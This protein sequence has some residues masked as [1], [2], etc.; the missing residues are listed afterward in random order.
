PA[1]T[2]RRIGVARASGTGH[3]GDGQGKREEDRNQFGCAHGAALIGRVINQLRGSDNHLGRRTELWISVVS[4]LRISPR[5]R[6]RNEVSVPDG[7]RVGSAADAGVLRGGP[8]P[9]GGV[10]S[11]FGPL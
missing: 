10:R 7:L 9:S 6:V 8:R 4:T 1:M 11:R 5:Y 2:A 3:R